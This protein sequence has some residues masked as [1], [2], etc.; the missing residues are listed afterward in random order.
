M[1]IAKIAFIPINKSDGSLNWYSNLG[2]KEQVDYSD[3]IVVNGQILVVKGKQILL[4]DALD[5]K[6]KK[7]L[8]FKNEKLKLIVI[9][10]RLMLV[11]SDLAIKDVSSLLFDS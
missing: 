11:M 3:P 4:I 1:L 6:I 5:G 2:N 8:D 10:G 9:N 7:T